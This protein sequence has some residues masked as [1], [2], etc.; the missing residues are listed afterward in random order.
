MS[1]AGVLWAVIASGLHLGLV[2]VLLFIDRL[3]VR[4]LP[5]ALL[6]A[7]PGVFRVTRPVP[8]Q[9]ERGGRP[10]R[11][12]AVI[13]G[14]IAGVAAAWS[15]CRSGVA[16]VNLFEACDALGGNAKT[17]EWPDGKITG[18][19]V[20]AWPRQYFRNYGC[21][22]RSLGVEATEVRLPFVVRGAS[23]GIWGHGLDGGLNSVYARDTRRWMRL[24][25][26][27]RAVNRAFH[28][29]VQSLYCMSMLNPMN[30][31]PLRWAA[32]AAGCSAVFWRDVIVP[33]YSSTFLTADM[34]AVPTVILPLISDIVPLKGEPRMDTWSTSS[35]DVFDALV[36]DSP[37]LVVRT[38]AAGSVTRVLQH[39]DGKWEVHTAAADA[40]AGFDNV[41]F[42]ANAEAARRALQ[43]GGTWTLAETLLLGGVRYTDE[44][45][46]SFVEGVVHSDESVFPDN[47]ELREHCLRRASNFVE[48]VRSPS[49]RPKV[50]NTFIV[51]SWCPSVQ[52]TPGT[53]RLV[54]YGAADAQELRRRV[55][56]VANVRNHP[57]LTPAGLASAYLLRTL[58]GRRGLYFI[59][60]SATPG[61]GHDLSL[62]S[63][64]AAAHALGA[65]HPFADDAEAAADFGRLRGILGL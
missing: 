59:G 60:S 4:C 7:V 16:E 18:L 22:L 62:C 15:L 42:A 12:V 51:S 49:G 64:L 21:L 19:S 17:I 57:V 65:P 46:N 25:R 23:G 53:A 10:V 41:I 61:N 36:R 40:H 27:V 26:F 29:D 63:G 45:N 38:G 5:R 44:T 58:Q 47:A 2:L 14:G 32:W 34:D 30:L 55:G 31:V 13:G 6:R 28:G 50:R 48:V 56:S 39:P 43:S 54:S 1:A 35:R 11:R 3:A 8:A 37:G 33:V 52:D 24:V 9:R 20:L